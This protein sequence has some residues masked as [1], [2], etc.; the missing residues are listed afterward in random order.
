MASILRDESEAIARAVSGGLRHYGSRKAAFWRAQAPMA[1]PC[2]L[3]AA[4]VVFC[5]NEFVLEMGLQVCKVNRMPFLKNSCLYI[6]FVHVAS[7]ATRKQRWHFSALVSVGART[8]TKM[9]NFCEIFL[10]P[11]TSGALLLSVVEGTSSVQAT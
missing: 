1:W 4:V 11:C 2:G 8:T 3:S 9:E 10:Y 7:K 6:Y 5:V